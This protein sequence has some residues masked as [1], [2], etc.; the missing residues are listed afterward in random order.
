MK[1][2]ISI[3]LIAS[4]MLSLFLILPANGEVK[5][6]IKVNQEIVIE[7]MG[8]EVNTFVVENPTGQDVNFTVEV[9]DQVE[10]RV[11]ETSNHS[12][13]AGDGPIAVKTKIY[14]ALP[15]RGNINTYKISITPE[16]GKKR[17]FYLAQKYLKD[18]NG[19]AIYLQNENV[20]FVNNTVTSFGIAFRD[21]SDKTKLWYQF[22][23]VDLS[24]QGR[25]T[26][27]LIAGNMY[28]IGELYV[29]VTDDTCVVSYHIY[30][31][32]KGGNTKLKKEYLNIFHNLEEAIVPNDVTRKEFNDP[33][34]KFAFNV[35]FSIQYDLDGDTK[36]LISMRNVVDYWMFPR[37]K[38][39]SYKRHWRNLVEYKTLRNSMHELL[40]EANEAHRQ[41]ESK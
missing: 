17:N 9:Y 37:A 12:M 36:V 41:A 24:I 11:I 39:A 31:D 10:K 23:P 26:F 18:A 14:K 35:P 20:F 16:N 8:T 28:E 34:T 1:R 7:G 19:L 13:A 32:G 33:E 30:Y 38:N 40:K 29:D 27:K 4:M 5:L 22:T 25:Q 6:K 3:L 15:K 2:K 21:I